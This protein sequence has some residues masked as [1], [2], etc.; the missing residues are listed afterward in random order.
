MKAPLNPVGLSYVVSWDFILLF[1]LR[2]HFATVRAPVADALPYESNLA[3]SGLLR[4]PYGS[5][6]EF[7]K[8]LEEQR[9]QAAT[10]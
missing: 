9:L 1:S 3:V 10:S 4:V 6:A 7:E 5:P 2:L 8:R